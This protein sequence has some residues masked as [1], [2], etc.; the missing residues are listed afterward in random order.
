MVTTNNHIISLINM[1]WCWISPFRPRPLP[2]PIPRP[3]AAALP[4]LGEHSP[5]PDPW[6]T[7]ERWDGPLRA[8]LA[9]KNGQKWVMFHSYVNLPV[10]LDI[11]QDILIYLDK[12]TLIND[13]KHRDIPISWPVGELPLGHEDHHRIISSQLPKDNESSLLFLVHRKAYI[14]PYFLLGK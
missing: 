5:R 3:G 13:K 6:S 7:R 10:H 11:F 8:E 4:T 9:M 2:R 1:K 14:I 12:C